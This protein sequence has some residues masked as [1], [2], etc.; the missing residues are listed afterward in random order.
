M[1]IKG[2]KTGGRQKGTKNKSTV[3]LEALLR[4]A[5][6]REGGV[7]YMQRIARDF[8]VAFCGM[9]AKL[10]PTELI[11]SVDATLRPAREVTDLEAARRIA[12][13]LTKGA[14]LA[15]EAELAELQQMLPI[16][17][18]TPSGSRMTDAELK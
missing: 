5:L 2:V 6:K 4:L 10:I 14:A 11:A 18:V 9:L 12:F 13:M 17:D 1:G 7:E 16:E 3:R 15:E 8:P